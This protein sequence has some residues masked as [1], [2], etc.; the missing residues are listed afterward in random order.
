M[1]RTADQMPEIP[2]RPPRNLRSQGLLEVQQMYLE[3]FDGGIETTSQRTGIPMRLCREWTKE[4]WFVEG[5]RKRGERESKQATSARVKALQAKIADRVELQSL[6]SEIA[7][8]SGEKTNDRLS[9]SKLLADSLG[10]NLQKV[11]LS[12]GDKPVQVN[13]T[14][15][16]DRIA[17]VAGR[18][19]SIFDS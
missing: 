4:D 17:L 1:T 3:A 7:F 14:D 19:S 12:G 9:A 18:R 10:M 16:A 6:W 13:H 5:M 2:A 8:D 11:E 15:I